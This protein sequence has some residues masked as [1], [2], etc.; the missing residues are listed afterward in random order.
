MGHLDNESDAR[1]LVREGDLDIWVSFG[2]ILTGSMKSFVEI[3][4]MIEEYFE[5][6][7][8]ETLIHSTASG[9]KLYIVK[10]RD[11][12]RLQLN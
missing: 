6:K 5:D 12:E 8:S 10:E 2:F 7:K 9:T 3:R 4:E 11:Y 1:D